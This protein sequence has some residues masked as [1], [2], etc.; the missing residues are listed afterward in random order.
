V[1]VAVKVIAARVAFEADIG[2]AVARANTSCEVSKETPGISSKLAS[3]RS[4][5]QA[6]RVSAKGLTTA[7]KLCRRP[8]ALTK[9]PDV[10]VNGAMGNS[11]SLKAMLALNGLSVTTISA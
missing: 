7:W 3:T 5:F 1:V 4:T 10:S 8:S 11:T 9:L 6:G 2:F